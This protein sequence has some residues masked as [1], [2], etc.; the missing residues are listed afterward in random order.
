MKIRLTND[1]RTLVRKAVRSHG[2]DAVRN[3]VNAL[4]GRAVIDSTRDTVNALTVN[5]LLALAKELNV[6]VRDVI[7]TAQTIHAIVEDSDSDSEDTGRDTVEA[8]DAPQPD[9]RISDLVTDALEPVAPLKGLVDKRIL[10][11]LTD[12]VTALAVEACKP[13]QVIEVQA[14]TATG[15]TVVNLPRKP[16]LA[17]PRPVAQVSAA[18]TFNVNTAALRNLTVDQWDASDAPAI[19]PDYLFD[20]ETLFD[21]LTSIAAGNGVWLVGPKG[22]GKTTLIQQIA[23]RLRRP[24]VRIDCDE[25]M[26]GRDLVGGTRMSGGTTYF[27]EGPLLAAVQR[28]GTIVLIDE[29]TLA[30]KAHATLQTCL[31]SRYITVKEDGGRVV[32]FA[33][34]VTVCAA[35]NTNGR[36]DSTGVYVGTR[37]CNAAFLDRFEAFLRVDYLAPDKE[38]RA[39]QSR[40][41]CHEAVATEIVRLAGLTRAK[42]SNG[43]MTEGLGLRRMIAW[44][45]KIA[46]GVPSARAWATCVINSATPEDALVLSQINDAHAKHI[47]I[48][49][50]QKGVG[51]LVTPV[52]PPASPLAHNPGNDKAR[53]IFGDDAPSA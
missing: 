26:E 11:N 29:P 7:A 24:F 15:A 39:I 20:A 49:Q 46:T 53:S 30:V 18:R 27:E 14:P 28:A 31:D 13:P 43:E 3:A 17:Q 25:L 50:A 48:D 8:H 21:A 52:A 12:R 35:D 2:E 36:G 34:G 16:A 33:P 37:P 41:G 19:D 9:T 22:T 5:E 1:A 44:G 10:D 51:P 6:D 32:R 45:R 47:H 40:A 4:K 23:A 38:A 42:A